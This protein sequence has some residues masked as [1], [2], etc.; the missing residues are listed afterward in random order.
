MVPAGSADIQDLFNTKFV[1]S[2]YDLPDSAGTPDTNQQSANYIT[3]WLDI[4]GFR[5]MVQ[6]DGVNYLPGPPENYAIVQYGASGDPPG[7]VDSIH[8]SSVKD[9]KSLFQSRLLND[10]N[11]FIN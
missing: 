11:N 8:W 6:E 4:V 10:L 1:N 2:A 5:S 9:F 7:S 3:A